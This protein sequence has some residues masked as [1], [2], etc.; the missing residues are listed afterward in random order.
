MKH[1]NSRFENKTTVYFV[2]SGER[3]HNILKYNEGFL[4]KTILYLFLRYILILK[5]K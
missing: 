2:S 5:S 4:Y 1:L 3:K